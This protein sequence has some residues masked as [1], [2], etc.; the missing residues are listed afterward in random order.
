[1]ALPPLSDRDYL[2]MGIVADAAAFVY[3]GIR[4]YVEIQVARRLSGQQQDLEAEQ[5]RW[6]AWRAKQR[7]QP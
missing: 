4:L 7:Y 1:M 2:L 6:E 3:F 5:R